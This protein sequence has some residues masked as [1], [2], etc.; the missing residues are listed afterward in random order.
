MNNNILYI[1]NIGDHV[2]IGDPLIKFDVS[3]ED[4]ELSKFLSLLEA[5]IKREKKGRICSYRYKGRR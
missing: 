3:V 4:D 5:M 1:A 2:N